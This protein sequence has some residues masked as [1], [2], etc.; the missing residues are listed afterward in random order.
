MNKIKLLCRLST[1]ILL[2]SFLLSAPTSL[3]EEISDEGEEHVVSVEEYSE[4][5][6]NLKRITAQQFLDKLNAS[7]AFTIFVGRP[8]C[9]HCRQFSPNIKEFNSLINNELYYYNTDGE[10]FTSL[11]KEI[12]YDQIGIP[13]VPT[14]MYIKDKEIKSGWIGGGISAQDLYDFFYLDEDTAT[15]ESSTED[16]ETSESST[17]EN[18]NTNIYLSGVFLILIFIITSVIYVDKRVKHNS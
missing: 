7:E 1:I 4:N 14:T 10:D 12:F 16:T 3:A 13:G 8:T 15:S 9:P 17:G 2:L 18:Q 5:I 11:G 6:S